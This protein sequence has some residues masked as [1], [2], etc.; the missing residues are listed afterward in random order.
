MKKILLLLLLALG[1]QAGAEVG[2][3][4]EKI[5]VATN[6]DR[7]V[8]GDTVRFRAFLLDAATGMEARDLSR[9]VYVE[10]IDPFGEVR[11]RVKVRER[12]GVFAGIL[13]LDRELPESHYTL[14]AYTTYMQNQ[15][16]EYFFRKPLEIRSVY[17]YKY[18]IEPEFFDRTLSVKLTELQSGKPVESES[19]I[20]YGPEGVISD[21]GRKKSARRFKIP[22]GVGTVKVKFD[23]YAKFIAIP[24]D[25]SAISVSFFPE[26]GSLVAGTSNALAFKA[27]DSDGRPVDVSGVIT[28]QDGSTV[29]GFA[30]RRNGIGQVHFV[31]AADATYTAKVGGKSYPLPRAEADATA[32]Q[33]VATRPQQFIVDVL[34]RKP[35]TA[36]LAAS[37]RG[38]LQ[39]LDTIAS[40][41][42]AI[43][44][45][46]LP[47]GPVEFL[48][49]DGEGR[50][51]SSRMAYNYAPAPEPITDLPAGSYAVSTDT[52]SL[53]GA[54]TAEAALLR[55]DL[56]DYVPD[57]DYYF[58]D[59]DNYAVRADMDALMLAARS[60]RYGAAAELPYP[61][62]IGG[63]I[64]G[65]IKSRWRG[66]PLD[67]AKINIL[68]PSIGVAG[69]APTDANGHFT[70]TG[71]NWP[72]GTLF[73]CQAINSKGGREHNFEL[74]TDT[75]PTVAPLPI[76]LAAI[77]YRPEG[78]DQLERA[79][80]LLNEIQVTARRS[81]E[82]AVEEMYKAMGMHL[83]DEDAIEDKKFTTYEEVVRSIPGIGINQGTIIS[84]RP[85]RDGNPK[86]EIWIDGFQWIPAFS[87]SPQAEGM[88]KGDSPA[89]HML[90]KESLQ[91]TARIMT[92]GISSELATQVYSAT[93]SE[94]SELSSSYPFSIVES[95]RYIPPQIALFVSNTAAQGG[96]ALLITTKSAKSKHKPTDF[97]IQVHKPLGYQ[98]SKQAL[99]PTS[100]WTPATS[101][102]TP[103]AR[104]TGLTPDGRFITR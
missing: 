98:D 29:A 6:G 87:L 43:P 75:F 18:H 73:A 4:Q 22:K 97:F 76:P 34:G 16:Q 9:Y 17:A 41:P 12:D 44:K 24:A 10:L 68:A 26:G 81:S 95:V 80:I 66:K 23:N 54:T 19:L 91:R 36:V 84:H 49:M 13:P 21:A 45:S 70:L 103:A 38:D 72:D 56:A 88:E 32:L 58:A 65:V 14:A 74:A 1:L 85:T 20:L 46:S 50:Q 94:L 42:V 59:R 40:F 69:E 57:L 30:T 83:F 11:E 63:E 82:E 35:S 25:S 5:H 8:S 62:E 15:G 96:G 92:G 89:E 77:E 93:T 37:V 86:V 90:M 64:S 31:P 71:I 51:L 104:I 33:V 39:L 78:A 67:N 102:P 60:D 47:A 2:F 27:V 61:V 79:G 99:A 3:P 100:D 53:S 101:T 48:L 55:S 7:F 28:D 52:V